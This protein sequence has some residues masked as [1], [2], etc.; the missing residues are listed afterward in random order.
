[1]IRPEKVYLDDP[2]MIDG[3]RI[4]HTKDGIIYLI[5]HYKKLLAQ[6]VKREQK[7]IQHMEVLISNWEKQ[8]ELYDRIKG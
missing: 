1:M 8:L 4:M 7:D 6:N 2:I 3:V 5:D